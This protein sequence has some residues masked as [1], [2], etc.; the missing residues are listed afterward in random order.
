MKQLIYIVFGWIFTVAVS[1]C[2][3]KLLLRG[4]SL[5]L[6]K[7]EENA[8]AFVLGSACVSTVVFFLAAFHLIYKGLLLAFGLLTVGFAVHRRVWHSS[9]NS[10]PKLPSVWRL[11]FFEAY[12]P[13]AALYLIYAFAPESSPDGS[14]YHLGLVA[15]Y[16][17]EHGFPAIT[18]SIFASFS[19]GMEML[20]LCAF[21][22]GRHSAAALV[23]CTYL[24]VLPFVILN[25]SRRIG[26]P[27]VGVAG[28][29]LIFLAP[30]AGITGTSAYNDIAVTTVVFSLFAFLQIWTE[31]RE[32]ALLIPIGVL[33]GFA[34]GIKYTAVI[35]IPYAL[36]F[37]AYKR[38]RARETILPPLLLLA[39]VSGVLV[40]PTLVKNSI[41]VH[42]PVAPFFNRVFPNPY[43]HVSFEQELRKQLRTTQYPIQSPWEIPWELAVG[44]EKLQGL[45]GPVF[46]LVPLSLLALRHPAGRQLL[47]AAL[48]FAV[49]YPLNI[50]TRFFLPCAAFLAPALILGV[51]AWSVVPV[52]LVLLHAY[53]S[54]PSHVTSYCDTY[55]YRLE[56]T[57]VR[58]AA[59]LESEDEY[60]SHRLGGYLLA[61][62]VEIET[63][64]GS[65]IFSFEGPPQAYCAR[66]ILVY[67][68]S[69][70]SERLRDTIYAGVNPDL[71]PIRV[72]TF[73]IQANRLRRIRL[74]QTG[75]DRLGMPGISEIEILGPEGWVRNKGGWRVNAGPFPW[76]AKLAFDGNPTTQWRAWQATGSGAFVDVDFGQ[77]EVISTVRLHVTPDQRHM[78]WR[79]EG[80]L[81]P[82][83]WSPLSAA[84]DISSVAQPMELRKFAVDELK[85]NGIGYLLVPDSNYT[86]TDFRDNMSRWGIHL[87]A[88]VKDTSLYEIE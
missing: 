23:H 82:G 32:T 87:R 84:A 17:R 72:L 19:Q 85:Q 88:K 8:L 28:G 35:A 18:T 13:F 11:L 45:L 57:P 81:S 58:A 4:L 21:V 30:V 33:A 5:R 80:K 77:E 9:G 24:L 6:D 25:Y 61:R 75:S 76:D 20:F 56:S 47:L 48:V 52:F 43:V 16:A 54:W 1:W 38:W 29:L 3:G 86:A 55:A 65:R 83:G 49:P 70:L 50:G 12:I 63:P 51:S 67:F 69:A 7:Q 74:V 68:E 41:V 36:A 46:L 71:Q 10:L 42:N 39:G 60:L 53:L 40:V 27:L 31:Q 37:V 26:M 14:T 62:R 22:F 59:R 34:F 78:R 2:S 73:N 66:E 15:R 64:P 79:L 44:G